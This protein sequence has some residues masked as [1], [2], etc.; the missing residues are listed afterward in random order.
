MKGSVAAAA[1]EKSELDGETMD[2]K[3]EWL[4]I[5]NGHSGEAATALAEFEAKVTSLKASW[6]QFEPKNEDKH[7]NNYST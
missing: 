2:N 5:F 1:V 3:E 6:A 7:R 4:Q